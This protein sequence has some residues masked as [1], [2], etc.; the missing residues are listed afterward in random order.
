MKQSK[1]FYR[2]LMTVLL[3][4]ALGLLVLVFGVLFLGC[5]NGATKT[6][7]GKTVESFTAFTQTDAFN[8]RQVSTADS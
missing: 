8:L 6:G 1:S 7:S 3:A 4:L 5:G 2:I